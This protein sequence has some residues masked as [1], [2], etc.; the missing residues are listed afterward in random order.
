MKRANDLAAG[1]KFFDWVRKMTVDA[2]Y[3]SP[4]GVKDLGY[5]GNKAYTKYE[6]PQASIDYAMNR[7][8]KM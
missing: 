1:T 8:P 4:I 2:Y 7:L 3:T 5:M 6:V